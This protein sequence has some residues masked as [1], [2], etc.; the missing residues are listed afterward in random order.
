MSKL[1]CILV[2]FFIRLS[3]SKAQYLP[4]NRDFHF[5]IENATRN[6]NDSL[7]TGIRPFLKE[8][9]QLTDS[10]RIKFISANKTDT[11]AKKISVTIF[12]IADGGVAY[13]GNSR[14]IYPSLFLGGGLNATI[15]R[16]LSV[17]LNLFTGETGYLP[18]TDSIIKRFHVVP[19]FGPAKPTKLGYAV[20]YW[21]GFI[22]CK[23]SHYFRFEAG[24]GK[25]FIGDGY[26]SLL[27][28][29]VSA[30]MPYFKVLTKIWKFNYMN[31][32][33]ELNHYNY[34]QQ[35]STRSFAAFH[36]L[37]CNITR[38]LNLSFFES[39]IFANRDTTGKTN[40]FDVNYLNPVV[41]YRP[42]E[43]SI[44]SADNALMGFTFKWNLFKSH[45]LYGQIALDEFY[46]KYV[47]N[48]TGWWANKQAFQ[49]GYKYFDM[50]SIKGLSMQLEGNYI[51]PY[52]YSHALTLQNYSNWNQPLAHP[53]GANLKE[54][55]AFIRYYR[56]RLLIELKVSALIYGDDSASVN[57]GR[58]I[59]NSYQ[60]RY[61]DFDNVTAQGVSTT[62][63]NGGIRVAYYLPVVR[64]TSVE[65]GFNFRS[66]KSPGV[67]LTY[68]VLF[69]GL[70][71]NLFNNY[72]DY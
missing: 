18:Y 24:R 20:N 50:F 51:R 4:L 65:A 29:D 6:N 35:K 15:Y 52:T 25:H 53:A 17:K 11:A 34:V 39:I 49:G 36:Y 60:S 10:S 22:S 38:K 54:G 72:S 56:A 16:R 19:G 5:E 69:I 13:T 45:Q 3:F 44:G 61:K 9:F 31:L 66:Q 43:Y 48:R 41:F 27:L 47:L 32:F 59:F 67:T 57:F 46:V 33:T 58:N 26:R 68:P 23:A 7:H 70:R 55:L 40:R 71:S 14:K 63:V 37:S 21:D 62:I 28:S 12:P 64:T 30:P 8:D 1:Y 2:V 42:V